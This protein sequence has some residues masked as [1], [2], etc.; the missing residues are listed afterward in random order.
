M[1]ENCKIKR[2]KMNRKVVILLLSLL[3]CCGFVSAE[4]VKKSELQQRAEAVDVKEN[5]ASARF[6]FIRAF[7]DYVGKGQLGQAVEII[8]CLRTYHFKLSSSTDK[9]W[10]KRKKTA[11]KL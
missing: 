2:E 8:S 3:F 4:D 7:E 10:K 9:R 11:A 6:L 1:H 5:I